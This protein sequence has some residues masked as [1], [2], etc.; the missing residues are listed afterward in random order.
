[1]CAIR[2]PLLTGI[3]A[4]LLATGTA[5]ARSYEGYHCGKLDIELIFEKY[6]S[7]YRTDCTAGP[8]DG[9]EHYFIVKPSKFYLKS[10]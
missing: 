3:A 7:P 2:K 4:L 9:K 1:M 6:F 5:H 10:R 8:C